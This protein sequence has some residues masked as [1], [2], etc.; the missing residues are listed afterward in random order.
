MACDVMARYK[1]MRGF[2]VYYLTGADEHGQKIEQK[3]EKMGISPQDYVDEMAAYM[4]NL[5]SLLE[6]TNDQ[7]IRT[8]S[9]GH[10][11]AIQK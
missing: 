4:Q 7:F 9:P 1:R 3:A 6:I 8:T 11:A 5:W 10:K 2:D